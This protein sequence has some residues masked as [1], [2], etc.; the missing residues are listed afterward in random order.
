MSRPCHLPAESWY[1]KPGMPVSTPQISW[2]RCLI[3]SSVALL[4]S[5]A[6]PAPAAPSNPATRAEQA[7]TLETQ[8]NMLNLPQSCQKCTSLPPVSLAGVVLSGRAA[9]GLRF[10]REFSLEPGDDPV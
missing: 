2:P 9:H 3:A 8:R 7:I 1:A 10:R 5:P 6:Q 4:T